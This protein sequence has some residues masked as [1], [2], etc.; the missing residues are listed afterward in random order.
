MTYLEKQNAEIETI[1]LRAFFIDLSDADVVRIY[2]KAASCG[3]TPSDILKNFIGDLV[4]GTS[5]N[6]SD[7]RMYVSQWFDRARHNGWTN[8]NFLSFILDNEYYDSVISYIDDIDEGK[9]GIK[10]LADDEKYDE[11]RKYFGLLIEEGRK[12]LLD[13]FNEYSSRNP[14]GETFTEAIA[15]IKST[16]RS[17]IVYLVKEMIAEIFIVLI[18]YAVVRI[19][20]DYL[21]GKFER[22]CENG[23]D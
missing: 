3:C 4:F 2:K 9:E 13:L 21:L 11:D 18:T 14:D 12:E 7:E 15:A 23:K 17:L 8:K 20:T 19:L 5:T 22:N 1:K 10:L 6:G 16:V